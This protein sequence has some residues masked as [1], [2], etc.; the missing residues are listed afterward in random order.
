MTRIGLKRYLKT[1]P[2]FLSNLARLGQSAI[3]QREELFA[4][5]RNEKGEYSCSEITKGGAC[6]V[7][8]FVSEG[9][10]SIHNHPIYPMNEFDFFSSKDLQKSGVRGL[11]S[12]FKRGDKYQLRLLLAQ[13]KDYSQ[14]SSFDFDRPCELFIKSTMLS[15]FK[16][17]KSVDNLAVDALV[18]SGLMASAVIYYFDNN[19]N[20]ITGVK[21]TIGKFEF[22]LSKSLIADE[23]ES[24]ILEVVDWMKTVLGSPEEGVKS[25]EEYVELT[26]ERIDRVENYIQSAILQR[27]K[28]RED[29]K[30][31]YRIES[32][33]SSVPSEIKEKLEKLLLERQIEDL[34]ELYTQKEL[35]VIFGVSEE[36]IERWVEWGHLKPF[37]TINDGLEHYHFFLEKPSI[38]GIKVAFNSR[39]DDYVKDKEILKILNTARI[40]S[41]KYLCFR[42]KEDL[43]K[44]MDKN[45]VEVVVEVLKK[46]G[47][48]LGMD[49]K[50]TLGLFCS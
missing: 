24:S 4:V 8:E 3:E 38:E 30:L 10:I 20:I 15:F 49:I 7:D 39:I 1:D 31:F 14:F 42:T 5:N 16:P 25:T 22:D 37:A 32:L 13:F 33:V 12:L 18:A 44:I 50:D 43:L 17:K 35:R 23:W 9:D 6:K 27:L 46:L 47:L 45:K 29:H 11:V 2:H 40:I 28:E 19:N 41:I 36:M 21:K 48:F 34:E 26:Q